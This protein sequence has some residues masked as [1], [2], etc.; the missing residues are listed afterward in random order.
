MIPTGFGIA[1]GI[2]GLILL[3]TGDVATMFGFVI[4][5]SLF[6]GSAAFILPAVGGS[7]IPPVHFALGFLVLR[8]LLP[9]S[10][11][12]RLVYQSLRQNLLL[13]IFV[14]YGV[15]I[16]Y[17][18]PRIFADQIK[19]VPMKNIAGYIFATF[20]LRPTSQ[21][22]TASVYMIG[23]L[24]CAIVSF[25]ACRNEGG[26]R[27]LVRAGIVVAGLHIFFG[28]TG[29]LFAD[30]A[31]S[32]FLEVVRNGSYAQLDQRIGNVVRINGIMPEPSAFSA[33]G[34]GWFVFLFE[35]WFRGIAA[36]VTGPMA[37]AMAMIL[38][39][40]TSSTA[41]LG[42]I[43]Y[44]AIFMVR[45]LLVPDGVS[46]VKLVRLGLTLFAILFAVSVIMAVQPAL[47]EQA[48]HIFTSMTTGKKGSVSALQRTFW[49]QQGLNAFSL[50]MGLGI[51]PGSFRSSSLP[52]AVAGATGFVG[53]LSLGAYL[54]VVLKP[55][56]ASTYNRRFGDL[57]SVGVSAAWAATC[58]LIPASLTSPTCD[59]GSDFAIFAGASL[60]LRLK[61]PR[62][63]AWQNGGSQ[64]TPV[65]FIALA[66]PARISG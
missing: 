3:L 49:A 7:S 63:Q 15:T 29:V 27:A 57:D 18:G 16:A 31:Y 43:A 34:F 19:I 32:A 42:L 37:L 58:L 9:G 47:V 17:A 30:T 53:M 48:G 64:D 50:S 1:I 5:C 22:I 45:T 62:A 35:C 44:A 11:Q 13:V 26:A 20:T 65:M 41:Y 25:V 59:P 52:T 21:N 36:R 51:G 56:R 6:G 4:L 39:A 12:G 28:L 40:S 61:R 10:R 46:Q 23:T 54:L 55:W 66:Q 60:A 33:Y 14:L 2:I 38:A 8:C 24:M